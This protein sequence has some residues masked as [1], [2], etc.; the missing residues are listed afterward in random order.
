DGGGGGW[1]G[2]VPDRPNPLRLRAAPRAV[3]PLRL[4]SLSRCLHAGNIMGSAGLVE[5]R[6]PCP[7]P[8]KPLS[9]LDFNASPAAARGPRTRTGRGTDG[10]R[11]TPALGAV[12]WR[13]GGRVAFRQLTDRRRAAQESRSA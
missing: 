11:R 9:A 8:R 13:G 10:T 6:G 12:S 5:S 1:G 4:V 7:G 3:D 2:H